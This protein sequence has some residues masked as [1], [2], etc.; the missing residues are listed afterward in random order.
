VLLLSQTDPPHLYS[1]RLLTLHEVPPRIALQRT[2]W[3]SSIF[4]FC[5][6][7]SFYVL[8]YFLPIYFQAVKGMS[9]LDSGIASIPLIF[10]NVIALIIVGV[11]V[12]KL[13]S[14]M[15]VTTRYEVPVAE[16]EVL[17]RWHFARHFQQPWLTS[18]LPFLGAFH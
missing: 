7:A 12:S 3:S 18:T 1:P 9:A 14:Y 8:I 4:I 2:V 16:A 5:L 6:S 11:L 15:Y 10:S 17:P 13:G